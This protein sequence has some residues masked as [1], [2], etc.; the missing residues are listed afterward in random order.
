M[1]RFAWTLAVLLGAALALPAQQTATPQP[2]GQKVETQKSEPKA[3]DAP[4]SAGQDMKNA[5]RSAGNATKKGAKAT[6]RATAKGVK[7]VG[8][9]AKRTVHKGGEKAEQGADKVE[10]KTE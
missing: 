10:H 2:D 7:K 9:A 8:H 6:G 3:A 5:G 4:S 1:K